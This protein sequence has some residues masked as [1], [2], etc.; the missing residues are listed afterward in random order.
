[1]NFVERIL[2]LLLVTGSLTLFTACGKDQPTFSMLPAGQVFRAAP[3]T[4]N[5]KLDILFLIDNQPSMSSFQASLVASFATFMSQFQNKGFDFK[6]AVATTDGYMADPTLAG[7]SSANVS[8][9]DF[10]DYNGSVHSNM[11]VILP[12]DP[13]LN[14][15]FAIN[16][17][18]NKDTAGQDARS[19]SSFRQALRNTRPV[20]TGFLR[21]D[22][23]FALVIVDNTDDFSNN[24]RCTGCN[25]NLRY[26]DPNIDPIGTYVSF[27]DSITGTTGV[28]ARYNVS[29]M[30]QIAT[31][32]QGG[33]TMTRI[34]S[35][36]NQAN[37]ITGDI[38]QA[39]YGTSMTQIANQISSLAT[40]YF[41]NRVPDP[42]TIVVTINGA[43]APQD[44][45]NCLSRVMGPGD[46]CDG[47]CR[48]HSGLNH[49]INL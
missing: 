45:N 21:P 20:N 35:L 3:T 17:K 22:S 6:I 15:D 46:R 31:P 13:N 49:S 23:F 11:F 37:G 41:L 42:S 12:G 9:A 27:L 5:N 36:V 7:Y 48:V 29:A 40:Q 1:M 10:N 18:P 43:I 38:C 19:F 33:T 14:N 16:A 30:T 47:G 32:C 26:N 8:L 4:Y 34:M 24:S 2:V 28:T 44:A 25:V 39:N